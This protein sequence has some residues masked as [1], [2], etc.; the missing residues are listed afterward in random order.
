MAPERI[1][2]TASSSESYAL[3]FKLLA[4][5]GDTVL[6]PQP[7]YPLF[8]H[9]ARL[10]GLVIRPYRLAFDGAWHLDWSS[11]AL[12]GARALVL[13][14]PNNPTGSFLRR[15]E[16]ARLGA[17]AARAGLALIVD[18][19]FADYAFAAPADAVVTMAAEPLPALTFA[20]GGLSSSCGLPQMKL[21]WLAALG[22]P[23]L[24]EA[25]LA[26]L[27]LIADTYLSVGTPVLQALPGLLAAGAAIR[28]DVRGR[29]AASRAALAAAFPAGSP[30]SVLPVEAGWSAILRLPAVRSDEQ[31]AFDLL[32][33]DGL[34]VQPGCFFA[35][36]HLGSP[37]VISL[38]TPPADLAPA[39]PA[40]AAA[41]AAV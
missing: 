32:D 16:L 41:A 6:V 20:L 29:L 37:I 4:D 2:L 8:D 14:N 18:E 23:P 11:L 40:I 36:A 7:S 13:C 1:V 3:L 39:L 38:L 34:L 12:E 27:E 24:A 30:V 17:E 15:D 22:P 10:E 25:A 35:L 9:L 26:R 33:R 28:K 19:V 5:P 31:W 21:G